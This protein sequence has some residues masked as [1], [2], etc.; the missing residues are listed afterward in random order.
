M[1]GKFQPA[2][3]SMRASAHVHAPDASTQA[4]IRTMAGAS[5]S[6]HFTKLASAREVFE[7]QIADLNHWAN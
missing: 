3:R 6:I 7:H 5:F 4:A 2:R 1:S